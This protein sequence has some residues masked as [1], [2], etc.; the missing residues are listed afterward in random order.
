MNQFGIVVDLSAA[1]IVEMVF[2]TDEYHQTWH[3]DID[4]SKRDPRRP[5]QS[6]KQKA[7]AD[8]SIFNGLAADRGPTGQSTSAGAGQQFSSGG[9]TSASS[10][11]VRR[12]R[13][14][15]NERGLVIEE[16][17]GEPPDPPPHQVG[18][19][20]GCG[21]AGGGAAAAMAR[22]YDLERD[23]DEEAWNKRKGHLGQEYEDEL[24]TKW[25]KLYKKTGMGDDEFD[26]DLMDYDELKS[27]W[28]KLMDLPEL[29]S[30]KEGGE[31][32]EEDSFPT[33]FSGDEGEAD[34]II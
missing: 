14:R 21:Q 11:P 32:S 12:L 25:Q 28:E 19:A 22:I 33:G 26:L 7:A 17:P 9:G 24:F 23:L 2:A 4:Q 34:D 1:D 15:N 10:R 16:N 27:H 13:L 6:Q 18:E 3:H 5:R 30:G 8:A 31:V 20:A 29:E